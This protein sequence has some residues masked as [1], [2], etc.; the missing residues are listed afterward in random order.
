MI[1]VERLLPVDERCL[2]RL[3]HQDVRAA[4]QRATCPAPRARTRRRGA[5]HQLSHS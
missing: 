3:R 4:A 1:A 2:L 5:Y